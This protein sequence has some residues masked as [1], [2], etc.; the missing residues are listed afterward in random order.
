MSQTNGVHLPPASMKPYFRV[1]LTYAVFGILWIFCSDQ[2]V[3]MFAHSRASLTFLQTFKG[4][5]FVVLSA[6]L[7]LTITRRAFEEHMRREREK[8]AVF[9]KTVEGAYHILLNYLN[10]MQLV[11]I[12]AEQCAGFDQSVLKLANAASAEATAELMK[13]RDIQTITAEHID[14]VIYEK[15]RKQAAGDGSLSA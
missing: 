1:A 2:L 5:L 15:L 4:W 6:L 12:E 7:I 8:I 11:T 10:Q 9:N 3:E 13:L 14:L